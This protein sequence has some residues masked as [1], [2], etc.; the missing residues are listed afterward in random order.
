[1]TTPPPQAAGHSFWD[2]PWGYPHALL[3]CSS[4]FLNAWLLQQLAG[5]QDLRAPAWP[6]NLYAIAIFWGG[7]CLVSS[8]WRGAR[9]VL[10]LSSVPLSICSLAFVGGLSLLAGLIPQGGEHWVQNIT[11]SWP[12]AFMLLLMLTNLGLASLR[13]LVR[14]QL[15]DW[16]FVANHCGFWIVVAAMA[17][18]APDLEK[19]R[20]IVAEGEST[21][22]ATSPESN[23]PSRVI[24]MPFE[25]HLNA[26]HKEDYHPRLAFFDL[27]QAD[28]KPKT[29]GTKFA[30]GKKFN[31]N[32][33]QAEILKIIETAQRTPSGFVESKEKTSEFAMQIKIIDHTK[34]PSESIQWIASGAPGEQ[35]LAYHSNAGVLALLDPQA[36][37]FRSDVTL[38]IENQ[39]TRSVS[40]EVN[41]AYDVLGWKIY[42]SSWEL[43]ADKKKYISIFDVI[44]DP[45]LPVVYVGAF[46]ML[47]GTCHLFWNGI[48]K[49][50][51]PRP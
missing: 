24:A 13:R 17:F 23:A 46:L 44:R 25:I 47:L 3:I 45:W 2:K 20:M 12:F 39:P 19:F 35:P 43:T 38:A 14:F 26:F 10:F 32:A 7:L 51:E 31:A 6:Y 37:L 11:G 4:L 29:I 22:Q 27:Q 15:R 33:L 8:L 41:K 21:S 40:I 30:I 34:T 42:Q 18:G 48:K 16:G 28:G 49:S 1:M 5:T 50:Q 9:V 36:K